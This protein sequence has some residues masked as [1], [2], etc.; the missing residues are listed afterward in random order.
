[1]NMSIIYPSTKIYVNNSELGGLGV[2]ARTN[3]KKDEEIEVA[4][5]LLIPDEQISSITKS[6]LVDYYFAWGK[7]FKQ[8][9]VVW[10]Y[11]SLFNHSYTPNAKYIKDEENSVVRFIA[12]KDI[13]QDEEI[14]INYNGHP[15]DKTKLWFEARKDL[16]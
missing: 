13:S 1:M 16:R 4:P 5:V 3:I 15:D 9:A 8:A 11:G 12:I 6:T 7:G 2:F 10:G 14:I